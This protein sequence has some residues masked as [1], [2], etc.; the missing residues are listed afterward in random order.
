[1]AAVD[2]DG[3]GRGV[4]DAWD[5]VDERRFAG[6]GGADDGEAGAGGDAQVDV[7]ENGDA[8]VSEIE[9]AEFDFA[10]DVAGRH[11]G[12]L[13]QVRLVGDLGLLGK[14]FV[15]TRHGRGSALED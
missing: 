14:D 11:A 4:V 1:G 10:E 9:I 8:V 2:E 5:Q 3:A 12:G 6:T 13:R 15:D 7:L